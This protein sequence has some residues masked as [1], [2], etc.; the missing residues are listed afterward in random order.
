MSLRTTNQFGLHSLSPWDKSL[1]KAVV[2]GLYPFKPKTV[3]TYV[4]F[5][6][7]FNRYR[8]HATAV[9]NN[10]FRITGAVCPVNRCDLLDYPEVVESAVAEALFAS[11]RYGPRYL[12]PDNIVLG[13]Y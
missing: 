7:D 2:E 11:F 5:D 1:T 13:E 9:F 8:I 4:E 12:A 10:G 3:E 6:I